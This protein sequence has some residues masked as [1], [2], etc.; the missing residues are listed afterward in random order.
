MKSSVVLSAPGAPPKNSRD[1]GLS[2]REAILDAATRVFLAH[3][4]EGASMDL[5]AQES[6]AARRTVY[7]QFE[8]KDA[9]FNAAVERV[10]KDM[11]VVGIMADEAALQ[12]PGLGLRKVGL[13][14]ADFWAPDQAVAFVR[15]VISESNRFPDLAENFVRLGKMPALRAL[16][17][18]ISAL[19]DRGLIKVEDPD[20]AARQF[21]G[22]VNEPLLWY[23]VIGV[24]GAPSKARRH[25]VVEEAVAT[26]LAR[27]GTN[28]K[29]AA[30]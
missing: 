28:G 4:Y 16:I 23:R 27:Y 12:D 13:L 21:V 3:G 26:F 8:S 24:G 19:K 10:W 25:Q 18:Y 30:S 2:K 20:L 1:Q 9:L 22:L 15:M 6:G 5:V 17:D 14:I 11:P 7:N 29:A